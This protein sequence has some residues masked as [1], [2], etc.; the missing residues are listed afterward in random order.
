M[1]SL[2][3]HKGAPWT[4][5]AIIIIVA[6]ALGAVDSFY[7]VLQYVQAI[8]TEGGPTPCTV[9]SIVSCTKT[10]QGDFAHYFTGIPNPMLGMLWYSGALAYGIA[11]LGGSGISRVSRGI[12][13]VVVLLGLLF[14]YRLYTASVFQLL[15]VCPFCLLSTVA[16]TLIALAFVVDD[17]LRADPVI[18]RTGLRAVLALQA[19]SFFLFVVYLPYFIVRSLLLLPDPMPAMTHWS[20]PV[21]IGLIL[22][23]ASA[24]VAAF[25]ILT[26]R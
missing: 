4:V 1:L 7:L 14:S 24:H 13:G 5:P 26:R 22:A 6:A 10:V 11:L 21:I 25:Q 19:V 16:S 8:V 2:R 15:G 18:G 3:H 17:R 9:N 20:M 23:M 12:V